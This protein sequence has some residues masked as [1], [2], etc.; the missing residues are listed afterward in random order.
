MSEGASLHTLK[1]ANLSLGVGEKDKIFQLEP[2]L[3]WERLI[4]ITSWFLVWNND[5]SKGYKHLWQ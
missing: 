2:K 3:P 4:P 1:F 5:P